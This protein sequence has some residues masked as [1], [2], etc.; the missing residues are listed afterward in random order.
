MR[1][2]NPE[3]EIRSRK[4]RGIEEKRGTKTRL[5]E[6]LVVNWLVAENGL[7]G[8]IRMLRREK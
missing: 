2:W 1:K 8:V 5:R 3:G 4:M 7:T 6:N